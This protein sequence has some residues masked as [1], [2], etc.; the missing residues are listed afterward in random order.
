[1]NNR[2]RMIEKA[3]DLNRRCSRNLV[4]LIIKE[5]KEPIDAAFI[6]AD[7]ARK[8]DSETEYIEL[9]VKGLQRYKEN[10]YKLF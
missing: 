10:G 1:M 6:V 8:A 3:I 9:L 5:V 7:A 4:K 2:A